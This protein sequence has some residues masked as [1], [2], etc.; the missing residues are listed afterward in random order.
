MKLLAISGGP[1]SMYLLD[2]YKNQQV[3][4]AHINYHKRIDSDNDERIVREFCKKYSIPFKVLSV[5]EKPKGNFQSWARKVRYDFFQK[6]YEEFECTKLLMAHHKDDFLETAKM[7][8]D[9]NREPRFYGIRKQT[10][11][12]GMKIERPFID[13]YWKDELLHYLKQ[14]N[15]EYAIDS[16]NAQPIFE[17]NK[18]RIELSKLSHKEKKEMLLWFKRA[19]KILTKKFNKVDKLYEKFK[20]S[21]YDINLF[22][23]M[24]YH[25]EII[26]E[27]IH[28]KFDNVKL[29]TQKIDSIIDFILSNE[30]GKKF[31]LSKDK[32]ISKSKNY[33]VF[34]L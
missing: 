24:K 29:S 32:F 14:S 20:N 30:G 23:K 5:K 3:V 21:N 16:S 10:E 33:I 4:V 8:L 13:L 2:W 17:R 34:S 9:S 26:Y 31:L 25:S 22:K 6:I 18:V 1:D 28:D 19:N 15:I 11:Y 12:Q 7:Q 27:M